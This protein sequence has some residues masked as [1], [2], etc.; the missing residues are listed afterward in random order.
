MS[1]G[2]LKIKEII[3]YYKPYKKE[4]LLDLICSVTQSG[5]ITLIPILIKC[6]MLDGL[7][8][9]KE[10]AYK[11]CFLF[12][13]IF[14]TIFIAISLCIKYR[15]YHGNM[16]ASK[17]ESDIKVNLFEH[18]QKQDFSF[19]DETKVGKLSSYITV[20]AHKLS[21]FIVSFP[22]II[23]DFIIRFVGAG[24]FLF[25][26]NYLF[27]AIIFSVLFFIIFFALKFIV[28]IREAINKSR[29]LYSEIIS[30]LNEKISGIKT[31]KT[32]T[33]EDIEL[34]KFK[35]NMKAYMKVISAKNKLVSKMKSSIGPLLEG[36]VPLISVISI[37]LF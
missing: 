35:Y 32:F 23:L 28:K 33:N 22:E 10:F 20:D 12:A 26:S 30:E 18:F 17:I 2:A 29:S 11:V 14:I 36:I 13:I 34:L 3:R 6:L 1:G 15:E 16:V 19:F 21:K 25:I 7:N 37:F 4:I 8:L 27:G 9:E 5:F 31:V 24:V